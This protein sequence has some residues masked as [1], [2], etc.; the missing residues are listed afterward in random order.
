MDV[1]KVISAEW[2]AKSVEEKAEFKPAK[3]EAVQLIVEV[4]PPVPE[5]PPVQAP[6]PAPA[7]APPPDRPPSPP[8]EIDDTLAPVS[9][10]QPENKPKRPKKTK[11]SL[12]KVKKKKPPPPPPPSSSDE[13]EELSSSDEDL[14]SV[15]ELLTSTSELSDESVADELSEQEDEDIS[16]VEPGR[17]DLP[18]AIFKVKSRFF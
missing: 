16:D 6:A 4:A 1:N 7:P 13:S 8:K 11:T 5:L 2:K 10:W 17:P 9:K 18:V 15:E 3:P 12:E 14:S